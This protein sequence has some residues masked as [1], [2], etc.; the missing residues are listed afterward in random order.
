MNDF[1]VVAPECHKPKF[2]SLFCPFKNRCV[3]NRHVMCCS[4]SFADRK[5]IK[6]NPKELIIII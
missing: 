3:I 5:I 1:T 6:N 4:Y 2:D